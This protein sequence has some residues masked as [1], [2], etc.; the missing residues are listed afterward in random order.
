MSLEF[1]E[2]SPAERPPS[3]SPP[4]G[5]AASSAL[6]ALRDDDGL[7]WV[8]YEWIAPEQSPFPGRRSL[9]FDAVSVV[10]RLTDYPAGWVLLSDGEL[11]ALMASGR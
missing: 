8:V 2:P 3:T 1:F 5:R 6:R 10:R 11:L 4:S 7:R 9:V